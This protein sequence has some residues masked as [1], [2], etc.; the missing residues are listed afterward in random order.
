MR[1]VRAVIFLQT[2]PVPG[3]TMNSHPWKERI[4]ADADVRLELD[5]QGNV[6]ATRLSKDGTPL[7]HEDN[8]IMYPSAAIRAAVGVRAASSHTATP[9]TKPRTRGVA[10]ETEQG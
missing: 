7:E 10:R 6:W 9:Y 4:V 8:P 5:E 1:S 3:L 2:S